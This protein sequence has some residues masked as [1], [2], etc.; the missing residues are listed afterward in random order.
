MF[1]QMKWAVVR[2]SESL[3]YITSDSPVSWVDP[4]MPPLFAYGLAAPKV[5]VTFPLNPSVAV[6]GRWNGLSGSLEAKDRHVK[7][8]NTRKV[9]FSDRYAF[10]H[11]EEGARFA[12]DLRREMEKARGK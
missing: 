8:F 12:L 5:E 7:E 9:G 11:T 1:D 6:L 3:R 10:A 4:T 2:A